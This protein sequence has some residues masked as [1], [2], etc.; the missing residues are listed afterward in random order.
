[1]PITTGSYPMGQ[2]PKGL[3]KPSKKGPKLPKTGVKKSKKT[4]LEKLISGK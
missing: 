3:K 1:M 2:K 4:L